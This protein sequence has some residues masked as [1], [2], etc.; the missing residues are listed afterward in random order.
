MQPGLTASHSISGPGLPASS[1]LPWIFYEMLS[2]WL[3]LPEQL[4][5]PFP[6]SFPGSQETSDLRLGEASSDVQRSYLLFMS[7]FGYNTQTHH[8]HCQLMYQTLGHQ[9]MGSRKGD[10]ILKVVTSP[11]NNSMAEWT[12]RSLGPGYRRL[13]TYSSHSP[14]RCLSAFHCLKVSGSTPSCL[15]RHDILPPHGPRARANCAGLFLSA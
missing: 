6:S 14:F 3:S 2:C 15:P 8:R 4:L 7:H 1:F 13:V 10:W 5:L 12:S 11:R 9:L